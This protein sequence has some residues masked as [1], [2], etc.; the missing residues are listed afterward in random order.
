MKTNVKKV[1]RELRVFKG[2]TLLAFLG[3]L[4][5]VVSISFVLD[6]YSIL[7]REMQVNYMMTNPASI[8]LRVTDLDPEAVA[9]IR[10]DKDN[11][12]IELRKTLVS[13]IDRG[14]GTYG[15]LY[16]FAVEDV[17]VQTVDSFTLENGELPAGVNQMALERDSLKN[18]TN[19]E[20]GYDET[21]SVL[22][23]GG[24]VMDLY[25][26]G[27][28][29]APG[30]APASMEKYSYAFLSLD[31]VKGLG[32]Q[33]WFDE[34]HLV[35]YDNRFDRESLK[36]MA[37]SMKQTL[38]ENGYQ[39]TRVD[40][41]EPGKH[42]HG[43]Q[44]RSLLFMLQAFTVISLLVAC[45]I[46]INLLNFIMSTQTR[47]IAIM[48]SAGATPRDIAP[49]YFLYVF[50]ISLGAI[51]V[52]IP[53]AKV[54]GFAYSDLAAGVLNFK[55]TSYE[56]PH[57]VYLVQIAI[58]ILVP[59]GASFYPIYRSSMIS[60]KEG[61]AEPIVS[62][63]GTSRISKAFRGLRNAIRSQILIPLNNVFRKKGRTFL[64]VLA[65]ATGGVLF[66]TA[67][68]INASIIKTSD[69]SMNTFAYTY[70]VR[71]FGVY[72]SEQIR[73]ALEGIEGIK[74]IEICEANAAVF[75]KPDGTQS[76]SY[77]IRALPQDSEMVNFTYLTGSD[78]SSGK[79]GVIINKALWED[80]QW[81]EPGMTLVMDIGGVLTE[82]TVTGIVNEIPPLPSV[83]MNLDDY[84]AL[85]AEG[86]KQNIMI[87]AESLSEEEQM[88]V[89]REIE[90][91]LSAAGIDV[92]ENWNIGLQRKAFVE[93]LSV[94][95][96]FLSVIALLAVVV[97]GLS[98]ASA[99]GITI[100]ERKRELGIL[101]AIG[102]DWRQT[103]GMISMEVI[104][105][106]IAG[107][108]LGLV[109]SYPISIWSGNY[110]GQIFLHSD[111]NNTISITGALI[112]LGL[113]IAVSF[114]SGLIPA[115]R[116]ANAPL[117]EMLAYE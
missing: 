70:D 61:L 51:I 109:L 90:Q 41:P 24:P 84:Q 16:L 33:G 111:L 26:S 114:L 68:N 6:S 53:L 11:M 99:I 50:L 1:L 100:A 107:W 44:L 86:S 36:S 15:T 63:A 79:N 96:I 108:L 2:R 12:D 116:S 46:I 59:L 80:E 102:A 106:G 52:G 105:M 21:V 22:L 91:N 113:S 103:I 56:I 57:W 47:Q 25:L 62:D 38:Q 39:V 32:Y 9:L 29:H 3:I 71:L 72:P 104:L 110:F 34:I 95:M 98:I 18:L 19:L 69:L 81:I 28:V 93:H 58:G 92:S 20:K 117:R 43:D 30:L 31:A 83:Y 27:T 55:I 49:P 97:G 5:G 8:V 17:A 88:N 65:L 4:I 101:R 10:G 78:L 37:A 35:S 42:P 94:I 87:S 54:F 112:W 40:V 85:G 74:A 76:A 64:A 82:V 60:V 75:A 66:M 45:I 48:K 73:S 13:R 89:S 7:T 77:T 115:Y 67:Q 23:P 14:N